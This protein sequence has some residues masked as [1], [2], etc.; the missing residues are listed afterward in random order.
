MV[1]EN[2]ADTSFAVCKSVLN[3]KSKDESLVINNFNFFKRIITFFLI[4][5]MLIIFLSRMNQRI[6]CFSRQISQNGNP[7][8][9]NLDFPT[10]GKNT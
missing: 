1:K 3:S 5:C 8:M 6:L 4:S 7:G 2:Q 9:G 10:H